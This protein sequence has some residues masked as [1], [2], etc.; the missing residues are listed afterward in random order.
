[1]CIRDSLH[2][3]GD[4]AA[5]VGVDAL[6]K[7]M[8][9]G[10]G[11]PQGHT[12]AHLQVVHPDD[13]QRIG[14]LGLYLAITHAWAAPDRPYDLTV[15]PF[16][17]EVS[18]D[19][20]YRPDGYYMQNVYPSR[21]LVEAGGVLVGGSDAPVDDLSPRPFF[22]IAAGISRMNPDGDVLNAAETVD[23]HEM[24]AAYT[25][26][27][28]RVMGHEDRVGSIEVGKRADLA[29]IDRNLLML[30]EEGGFEAITSIID[31][32]VDLTVFDGAVIF[33][34]DGD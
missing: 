10:A 22:N 4:R 34:R 21:S 25:I 17:D 28:A 27:G 2:A 16:I 1:M 15:I 19:D 11:N 29:V 14:Q 30:A 31:T 13:Q 5:R 8:D 18:D 7:V 32:Q 23:V 6:E 12:L 9:P 24:I 26:N 3:I 20:L 33:E